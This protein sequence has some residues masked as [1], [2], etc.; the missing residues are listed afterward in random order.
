VV[1]RT[2]WVSNDSATDIE[3]PH[4]A[5][6]AVSSNTSHAPSQICQYHLSTLISRPQNINIA[7]FLDI[8]CGGFAWECWPTLTETIATKSPQ[9]IQPRE[10]L[11]HNEDLYG[12][13]GVR[14]ETYSLGIDKEVTIYLDGISNSPV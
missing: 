8:L 11:F 5:S 14:S 6:F 9:P 7:T 3:Y 2:L 13:L 12:S 10:Q 4:W 1:P